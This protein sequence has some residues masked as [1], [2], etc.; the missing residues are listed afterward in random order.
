V[1]L[2]DRSA[3]RL[4]PHSVRLLA[5]D[6]ELGTRRLAHNHLPSSAPPLSLTPTTSPLLF[7]P[8]HQAK[9]RRRPCGYGERPTISQVRYYLQVILCDG[10]Y[11]KLQALMGATTSPPAPPPTA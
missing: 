6:S 9:A 3:A 5:T 1:L 2:A 10:C 11:R 4:R 8:Y 7:L